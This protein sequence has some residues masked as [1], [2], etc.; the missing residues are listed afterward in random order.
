MDNFIG[1]IV[2]C[3][4]AKQTFVSSLLFISLILHNILQ[5][6]MSTGKGFDDISEAYDTDTIPTAVPLYSSIIQ[7]L[8][9]M[10]LSEVSITLGESIPMFEKCFSLC[11]KAMILMSI[12]F[13]LIC[14]IRLSNVTDFNWP[15]LPVEM[16][17]FLPKAPFEI[18]QK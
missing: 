1:L 15:F 7:G 11:I 18:L 10:P 4:A 9:K 5:I 14:L 17:H 6:S 3:L 16:G 13:L 12:F 8:L 2:S